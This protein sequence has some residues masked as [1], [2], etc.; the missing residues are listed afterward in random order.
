M[1]YAPEL[2]VTRRPVAGI[3]FSM[4][5]F[6]RTGENR[7]A[8]DYSDQIL[9][10]AVAQ[11]EG[12]VVDPTRLAVVQTAAGMISRA[13]MAARMDGPA[14]DLLTPDVLAL[15]GRELVIRGEALFVFEGNGLLPVS[16]H[17]IRGSASAWSYR[18]ELSGP[19]QTEYRHLQSGEILH[20][21]VNVDPRHPWRGR[22]AHALAAATSATAVAAEY[23]AAAEARIGVSRVLGIP[24]VT[25]GQ[26]EKILAGYTR[27]LKAGSYMA[28]ASGG[29][30]DAR[31]PSDAVRVVHPD[32][33]Q[34]HLEL[35]TKAGVELLEAIG[36]PSALVDPRAEGGATREALRRLLH[37]TIGPMA[38]T[39]EAEFTMKTGLPLA[40]DFAALHATDLATRGRALKQLVDAGVTLDAALDV[41]GIHAK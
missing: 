10:Q 23:S 2:T 24:E 21:R 33:S 14:A 41:V 8:G 28:L 20:F 1:S 29:H 38:R 27:Q 9:N 19:T 15:I 30:G 5:P 22:P 40:L 36:I 18:V 37:L 35:R 7:G 6:N 4:W 34:G 12:G 31:P 39:V 11:A 25:P 26:R 16:P 3:G 13:F 17:D 32:P